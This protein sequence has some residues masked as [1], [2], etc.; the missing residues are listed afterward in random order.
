MKHLLKNKHWSRLR[1]KS[2]FPVTLSN[3]HIRLSKIAFLGGLFFY[4]LNFQSY[5]SLQ[6][7]DNDDY[8]KKAWLFAGAQ[9][10]EDVANVC[11]EAAY[12][13]ENLKDIAELS[14]S[15]KN[16]KTR[17]DGKNLDNVFDN[18]VLYSKSAN[19][20]ISNVDECETIYR[21]KK[22][23]YYTSFS[24][25]SFK[26]LS[27]EEIVNKVAEYNRQKVIQPLLENIPEKII[28]PQKGDRRKILKEKIRDQE[29]NF[30]VYLEIYYANVHGQARIY[31]GSGSLISENII[32][33]AGHNLYDLNDGGYP[34]Q[35]DCFV[36]CYRD[37]VLAQATVF[38]KIDFE[39]DSP[40]IFVHP[41]YIRDEDIINQ[42]SN[43]KSDVIKE[44]TYI[45]SSSDIGLILF[46]KVYDQKDE[47][48]LNFS[49]P[50]KDIFSPELKD[51]ILK[52]KWTITGYP[53]AQRA[54]HSMTNK[55]IDF[56]IT[57]NKLW[58]DIDTEPGQSG[59]GICFKNKN[60]DYYRCVGIHT[61]AGKKGEDYNIGVLI[62]DVIND[63]ILEFTKK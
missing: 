17:S 6:E 46:N 42:V 52:K 36:A 33:T 25:L 5:G 31:Y 50:T 40:S 11:Y 38:P 27:P 28:H 30:N 39:R 48:S 13:K 12:E 35:I 61:C 41:K 19:Q 43:E 10:Q 56:D 29:Y 26:T 22:D 16:I 34:D 24:S 20:N 58:Y 55:I 62:D 21:Q 14:I 47:L 32:L 63:K 4:A 49:V 7:Q 8:Q 23:S 54:A 2:I 1:L 45:F 44:E 18:P 51:F 53:N 57:K 9:N 15:E 60:E 3:V 59:S 37:T